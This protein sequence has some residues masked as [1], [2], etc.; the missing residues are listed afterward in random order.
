M[1]YS[2]VNIP[3]HEA[4]KIAKS[5][6]CAVLSASTHYY[7]YNK[8]WIRDISKAE[9]VEDNPKDRRL[10][11]VLKNGDFVEFKY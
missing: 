10:F 8:S 7:F 1:G 9:K 6:E 11:C 5:P 2:T 4:K 3:I